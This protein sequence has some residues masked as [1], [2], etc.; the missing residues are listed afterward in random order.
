MSEYKLIYWG[1]E[2]SALCFEFSAIMEGSFSSLL[3]FKCWKSPLHPAEDSEALCVRPSV[4]SDV[5]YWVFVLSLKNQHH[6]LQ[7]VIASSPKSIICDPSG[8]S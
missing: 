8:L 7:R 6:T 4:V 2:Q 3:C 1:K 5:L